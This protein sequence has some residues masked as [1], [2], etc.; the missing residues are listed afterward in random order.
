M[1]AAENGQS[2]VL[3]A[4]AV[5]ERVILSFQIERFNHARVG[6][7]PERQYHP[8]IRHGVDLCDEKLPAVVDLGGQRL[9]LR[10]NTAYRIGDADAEQ[11]EPVIGAR[12]ILSMGE[13]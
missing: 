10:R 3:V 6:D 9:V 8:Q 12:L 4:R 7:L 13:S 11:L 5:A 2:L 1:I